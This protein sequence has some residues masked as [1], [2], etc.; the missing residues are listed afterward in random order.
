M[1]DQHTLASLA[2]TTKQKQ[3]KREC[4]LTAMDTVIPWTELLALIAPHSPTGTRGR[5]PLPLATMLRVYF[6]QQ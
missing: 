1:A 4:F 2:Y 3:T 5:Q 6:L